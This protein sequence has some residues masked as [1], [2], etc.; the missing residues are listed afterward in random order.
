MAKAAETPTRIK[1]WQRLRSGRRRARPPEI[2]I[3]KMFFFFVPPADLDLPKPP[4]R[5][6]FLAAEDWREGERGRRP[7]RASRDRPFLFSLPRTS[8]PPPP[9]PSLSHFS[10]FS[11]SSSRLPSSEWKWRIVKL[12]SP[13]FL[14]LFLLRV[15][16]SRREKPA[17]LPSSLSRLQL[18]SYSPPDGRRTPVC[19]CNARAPAVR[20][21]ARARSLV[22]GSPITDSFRHRTAELTYT[23]FVLLGQ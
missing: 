4:M 23:Q 19:C 17:K 16:L 11:S 18:Q 9:S 2:A 22:Q 6:K 13:F 10:C 20:G 14:L 15:Y 12:L 7:Q 21:A 8:S 3:L 1:F 5:P